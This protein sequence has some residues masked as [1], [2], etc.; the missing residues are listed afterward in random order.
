MAVLLLALLALSAYLAFRIAAGPGE[1]RPAE[2]EEPPLVVDDPR[3]RAP[4]EG[5]WVRRSWRGD[6]REGADEVGGEARPAEPSGAPV[7]PTPPAP[8]EDDPQVF[9]MRRSF[10]MNGD[11]GVPLPFEPVNRQATLVSATGDRSLA[12][13]DRCEVRVLPVAAGGFNCLVRVMC[14]GEILYPNPSQTAG[15]VP[16]RVDRGRPTSARDGGPTDRDGDPLVSLDLS[17]G[18][19]VVEDYGPGVERFT[20]RL[21]LL[22]ATRYRL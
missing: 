21:R 15:Y 5:S 11:A 10:G 20:A 22:S 14:G 6:G 4:A 1:L 8:D 16:C 9:A 13:G 18:S 3:S 2:G 19:V 17:G 7:A 12:T